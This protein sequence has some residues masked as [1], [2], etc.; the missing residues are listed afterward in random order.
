MYTRHNKVYTLLSVNTSVI[1]IINCNTDDLWPSYEKKD[2][3]EEPEWVAAEREQFSK[4]RDQDGN[5]K[6]D[7]KEL[8]D[9]IVPEDFDHAEA[10][11]K[12]LIYEADANKV[13]LILT[14]SSVKS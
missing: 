14:L 3:K 9:W 13:R 2:N 1:V 4:H 7:K 11:A 8:G 5:G 12:H 6:L 10:E